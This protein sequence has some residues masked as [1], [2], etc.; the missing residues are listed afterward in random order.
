[1][2]VVRAADSPQIGVSNDG[3]VSGFQSILYGSQIKSPLH[4]RF[5]EKTRQDVVLSFDTRSILPIWVERIER[6]TDAAY[7]GADFGEWDQSQ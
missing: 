3:A 6:G 5:A 1:M 7:L 4:F 2:G